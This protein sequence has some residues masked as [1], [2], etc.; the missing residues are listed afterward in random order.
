MKSITRKK[1]K[2]KKKAQKKQQKAFLNTDKNAITNLAL[3]ISIVLLVLVLLSSF[4]LAIGVAPSREV[5]DYKEGKQTLTA[6]I[7]NNDRIDMR[8]AAYPKGE[9]A[10]YTKIPNELIIVKASE[11]EKSFEYEINLPKGLSPGT[12]EVKII[13]VQLP[14]TFATSNDNLLVTGEKAVL[15]EN[16]DSE[17]VISATSA[18]IHQLHIR[19]PYPESF[20]EGRLYVSEG[21][22]GDLLEFAVPVI[23]RGMEKTNIYAEIIIKGPTNEEIASFK[24]ENQ[25][26]GGGKESKLVGVWKADINQGLYLAEA[27]VHYGNEHFTLRKQFSVGNV[28]I[29]IDGMRVEGFKLGGIAK[30]DVSVKNKWNEEIK[31]VYGELKVLD[32][33]G[34]SLANVKT[35]SENVPGYG[36]SVITGYWDTTGVSIG[37]YDVNVMLHYAGKTTERLFQTVVGIDKITVGQI[38]TGKVAGSEEG[39][40]SLILILIIVVVLL[41]IANISW[42]IFLRKRFKKPPS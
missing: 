36:E 28:F 15:F 21:K 16:K 8:I 27:I 20:V 7:I 30:F 40:A 12:R 41:V 14:E 3:H 1:E 26:L 18:V 13:L 35:L 42:F 33:E 10:N 5:I 32:G 4:C 2:R 34:R 38:G 6:R 25:E 37:R 39:G 31:D 29:S 9:L 22:V 23:N 24:T 17:S 19:V 11:G